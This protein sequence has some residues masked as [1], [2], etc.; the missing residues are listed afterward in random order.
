MRASHLISSLFIIG[1]EFAWVAEHQNLQLSKAMLVL[2]TLMGGVCLP[3]A[4][5][6]QEITLLNCIPTEF[7]LRPGNSVFINQAA[8]FVPNL[9]PIYFLPDRHGF[10]F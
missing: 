3:E 9:Y 6:A 4:G 7:W 10:A 5:L 1:T 8:L 2:F